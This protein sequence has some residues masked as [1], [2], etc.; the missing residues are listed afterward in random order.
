MTREVRSSGRGGGRVRFDQVEYQR[1]VYDRH[2]PQMAAAVRKRL[3]HPLLSSFYDRLARRVLALGLDP[4]AAAPS[5]QGPVKLFEAGCGEGLL[6]AAVQ[7]VAV[8]RGLPFEYTG[9]DLSAAGVDLARAVLAGEL[10]VGDA[11]QVVS[12][13]PPGSQHVLW[14]KN[15]L[16]H[17]EDPAAF[18]RAALR[19]VGPEGRVVIVEPRM[20]C[21]MNWVFLGWFRQERYQFLGYRRT[22]AAFRESGATLEE[23]EPFGWLPYELALGTRLELPRRILSS[24]DPGFLAAVSRLDDRLTAIF[25]NL[26]LYA[27]SA[28]SPG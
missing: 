25:P 17:L 10:V 2:Y 13:L 16:H 22:L 19:A 14:A 3:S 8:G 11:V 20:W 27:V 12:E 7:R 21:P 9:T 24:D 6:G 18:L 23:V 26:A 15:L 1:E 28:L 4:D 5:S